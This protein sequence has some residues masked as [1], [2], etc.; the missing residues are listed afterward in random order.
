MDDALACG[1]ST[2][3]PPVRG[4]S[5]FRGYGGNAPTEDY[6]YFFAAA[7]LRTPTVRRGPR[8]VR[9]LVRVR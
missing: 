1:S 8:R 3:T 9:A 2:P 5:H 4:V 6:L 7:F